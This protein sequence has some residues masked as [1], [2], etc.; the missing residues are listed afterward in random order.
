M[1]I[2]QQLEV[3]AKFA[4]TDESLSVPD[5][6]AIDH[7]HEV[8]E[9]N[10][11]QLSAVYYD[12]EDLRLTRS[13]I[14]LRRRVGGK[15]EGWHIKLPARDG[16]LE[17]HH[18]LTDGDEGIVPPDLL[19][20]VASIV[21]GKE[22]KPIARVDNE[23]HETLMADKNG[24]IV[25]EF[26]DDHVSTWS[27]LPGGKEQSW[28]EWEIE[29]TRAAQDHGIAGTI[30]ASASSLLIK[31]GAHTSDSPSKL[32]M[33]LGDSINN[34][35]ATF[36]MA[37][38]DEDSPAYAVLSALKRNRDKLIEF[39]PKVRRDEWDSIHQMRVATRELRSHMQTFE[40][41]L[42]GDEY[43]KVEADLKV[44]AGILGRARD[45]EV[46]ADRFLKLLDNEKTGA[47]DEDAKQ[48]LREDMTKKYRFEHSRVVK[49]LNNPRY[50]Q[51]LDN[52]DEILSNPPLAP[53]S[54][55]PNAS[56]PAPA[57]IQPESGKTTAETILGDH[58][59][60]AYQ[61]LVRR[62]EYAVTSW[63]D[64]N[65]SLH[66]RE[67]RFHSMRKAAKKLRY[68]AEAVGDATDLD[69]GKLYSA[70]KNMQEVLG[71]FQDAVTSRDKLLELARKAHRRGEDTFG[72]GVLFQQE[73]QLSLDYLQDYRDA[74]K[75]IK[76]A[77]KK[78]QE[79]IAENSK[80]KAKE[81]AKARR[82]AKKLAEKEA[83]AA[84]KLQKL[85][86]KEE[87]RR[88][89]EQ[90]RIEREKLAA[91]EELDQVSSVEDTADSLE[92]TA[93]E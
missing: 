27:Y 32:V 45:A 58:L 48:H 8:A 84:K 10:I 71:D 72:Y 2:S 17:L 59:D 11:F 51:L 31:Q 21:R 43:A 34:A 41:I 68:A 62:H 37:E 40:G 69:T 29:A 75:A 16:R 87:K 78:L 3:E 7:V 47:L 50:F 28:R 85:A 5:F 63:G 53:A 52:L 92:K 20:N 26:C 25:A 30:I 73:N 76:K 60:K 91:V 64:E 38:L 35:P 15:D 6:T 24:V 74:F 18:D 65:L 55:E 80:R 42:T 79:K 33:A 66:E 12:T 22:L 56:T 36:T 89:K 4:L 57:S 83:E 1:S 90:A 81:A 9:S 67:D 13:K 19:T 93:T 61:R 70:C 44:L 54:S 14:T 82:K 86:R 39:D 46:V 77:Y 49:I 88:A 23:R